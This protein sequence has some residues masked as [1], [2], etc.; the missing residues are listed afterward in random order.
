MIRVAGMNWQIAEGH[1]Q[2]EC[3]SLGRVHSTEV[4][5]IDVCESARSRPNL[6]LVRDL[7][8]TT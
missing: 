1:Q 4:E 7:T 8:Q 3:Y 6:D 5:Q 2:P